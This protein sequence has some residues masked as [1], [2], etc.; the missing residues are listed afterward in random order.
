MIKAGCAVPLCVGLLSSCQAPPGR[1]DLVAGDLL[2]S[3]S[4]LGSYERAIT[5][6]DGPNGAHII[7]LNFEG[8]TA[9]APAGFRDNSARNESQIPHQSTTIPPFDATG[10]APAFSRAAV[11]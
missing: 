11:I 7:Y 1:D 2:I 9:T 5:T 6:G 8:V 10:F 3:S 4:K